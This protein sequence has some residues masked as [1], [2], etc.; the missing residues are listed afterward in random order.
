MALEKNGTSVE[1]R[2]GLK[3]RG[4]N[5]RLNVHLKIVKKYFLFYIC[6]YK[7]NNFKPQN[8]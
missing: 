2:G 3:C 6:Y 5:H 7:K 8:M 4:K 1:N